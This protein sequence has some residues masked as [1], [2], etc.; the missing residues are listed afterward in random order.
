MDT[1]K[2]PAD[3]LAHCCDA[4]TEDDYAQAVSLIEAYAQRRKIDGMNEIDA[5]YT[6]VL[7]APITA[8]EV[9]KAEE[10]PS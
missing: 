4:L 10:T 8:A 9:A 5:I 7:S 3:C 6:R 1:P 2:S